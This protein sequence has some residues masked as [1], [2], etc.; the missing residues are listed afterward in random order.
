MTTHD[1]TRAGQDFVSWL[2]WPC[3]LLISQDFMSG[4]CFDNKLYFEKHLM[5]SPAPPLHT[6]QTL[7]DLKGL[8]TTS[9]PRPTPPISQSRLFSWLIP[10]GK[11]FSWWIRLDM[12]IIADV[13]LSK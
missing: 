13:V 2:I 8:M 6:G 11:S 3:G 12:L 7:H 5:N 4:Y 1:N 9:L 10:E